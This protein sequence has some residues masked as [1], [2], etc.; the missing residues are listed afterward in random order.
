MIGRVFLVTTKV[1]LL[2]GKLVMHF[3]RV[4]ILLADVIGWNFKLT[5]VGKELR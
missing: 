3:E 5:L 4:F 1:P 2:V